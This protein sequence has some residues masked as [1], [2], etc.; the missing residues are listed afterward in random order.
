MKRSKEKEFVGTPTNRSNEPVGGVNPRPNGTDL[1][2]AR[3]I[4]LEERMKVAEDQ[5]NG[6]QT[7]IQELWN[8]A[9]INHGREPSGRPKSGSPVHFHIADDEEENDGDYHDDYVD[10]Q[11]IDEN[12]FLRIKDLHHLK[13]PNLP[14][15]AAQFRTWRNATRTAILAYDISLLGCQKLSR[16]GGMKPRSSNVIPKVFPNLTVS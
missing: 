3:M 15:T 1:L 11:G 10:Q 14:E 16:L 13:L 9:P 4:A 12:T 7:Y 2:L 8:Q 6:H 5:L